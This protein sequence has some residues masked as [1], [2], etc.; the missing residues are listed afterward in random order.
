M[1]KQVV[2]V[3]G[4]EHII[5][6]LPDD[7][8][9]AYERLD[10]IHMKS[11]RD[12]VYA[13]LTYKKGEKLRTKSDMINSMI[14]IINAVQ[15]KQRIANRKQPV[16][17]TTKKYAQDSIAAC[18]NVISVG[19]K[20]CRKKY[21]WLNTKTKEACKERSQVLMAPPFKKMQDNISRISNN[22]GKNDTE[23]SAAGDIGE[24]MGACRAIGCSSFIPY[25]ET[26]VCAKVPTN[27]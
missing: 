3:N 8:R 22:P 10:H 14:K 4:L 19:D 2:D 6:M 15:I 5:S 26:G 23:I 21:G 11:L 24:Y 9:Q 7:Q 25:P 18:R 16:S 27:R 20:K 12:Y 13:N 17:E 1:P